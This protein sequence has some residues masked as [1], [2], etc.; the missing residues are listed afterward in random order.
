MFPI[1]FSFGSLHV[2][3][4]GAMVA[5]GV[6]LAIFLMKRRAQQN[7]LLLPQDIY[8]TVFVVLVSGFLG[9]RLLYVI[10]NRDFY[11]RNLPSIFAFWE[12]GLIF[13]GGVI[14]SFVAVILFFKCKKLPVFK[15][16]DFFLPYVS[17]IHGFGRIGCFL[18]GCCGGK[19]C[20]FPWA[21]QFPNA[22]YRVHPAQLY[23]AFLDFVIFFIL[24]RFHDKNHRDGKVAVLYFMG[25]S[26]LRFFVEFFRDGNA[27]AAGL[28]WNQWTSIGL[29]VV[30]LTAW[31]FLKRKPHVRV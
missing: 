3:S 1:I 15:M 5:T 21:V 30:S 28:S 8:D 23:E 12:G 11:S 7:Q 31:I 17:F 16:L 2:Y 18:N 20:D 6:I 19:V 13:Y 24:T 9:A 4:F 14:G 26:I 10:E 22:L 25:Y 27:S 29:F